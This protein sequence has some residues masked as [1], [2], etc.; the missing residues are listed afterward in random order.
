MT[1]TDVETL[2][3]SRFPS[4][5]LGDEEAETNH[6]VSWSGPSYTNYLL[7]RPMSEAVAVVSEATTRGR[8]DSTSSNPKRATLKK[9][10]TFSDASLKQKAALSRTHSSDPPPEEPVAGPS[11]LPP[12][13]TFA[14]ALSSQ[15]SNG[16]PESYSYSQPA[17]HHNPADNVGDE[18]PGFAHIDSFR[19]YVS[20][21]THYK[22]LSKSS[23]LRSRPKT[24][25]TVSTKIDE[26]EFLDLADFVY[27]TPTMPPFPGQ[28]HIGHSTFGRTHSEHNDGRKQMDETGLFTP[29]V[30][31]SAYSESS[32]EAM[33]HLVADNQS[34][35]SSQTVY[36]HSAH[37]A[38][39]RRS[40]DT[41]EG[42]AEYIPDTQSLR[43]ISK[44]PTLH[45]HSTS[46]FSR[47][48]DFENI[49]VREAYLVS[50]CSTP[51]AIGMALPSPSSTRRFSHHTPPRT[52][53]LIGTPGAT[54]RMSSASEGGT[55]R[56]L[57]NRKA[58]SRSKGKAG[59]I[60]GRPSLSA[61]ADTT[62]GAFLKTSS[63][64]LSPLSSPV[65]SC[66]TLE[67]DI[68]PPASSKGSTFEMAIS[69]LDYDYGLALD[70]L[71]LGAGTL[72]L[73]E[74]TLEHDRRNLTRYPFDIP[75]EM[76]ILP[77]PTDPDKTSL[78][79][80]DTEII[81]K[82]FNNPSTSLTSISS[83]SHAKHPNWSRSSKFVSGL[84]I[85]S[86]PED[87]STPGPHPGVIRQKRSF[88]SQVSHMFARGS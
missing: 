5:T 9:R 72:D 79:T 42:W 56:T 26:Q 75:A 21:G 57:V 39:S 12:I 35:K 45:T 59:G 43:T 2:L 85:A 48:S 11:R 64:H 25:A 54:W 32:P 62:P 24:P 88:F 38:R 67:L 34:I 31:D 82:R 65:P 30:I 14:S 3:A 87:T 6:R 13:P 77:P 61:L 50:D 69:D 23:T 83:T 41:L 17:Y 8:K 22:S 20:S 18:F 81:F 19:S 63:H 44:R 16:L 68:N 10:R 28:E 70:V 36:R 7:P 86:L 71:V 78:T 1:Y 37:L 80:F 40:Q 51:T 49:D 52:P 76:D 53:T 33:K 27:T 73:D 4:A 60:R 29:T 15:Q 58:F 55:W 46:D 47:F 84:P 66:H 74:D